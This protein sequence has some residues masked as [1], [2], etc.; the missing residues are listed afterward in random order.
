[1]DSQGMMRG[2]KQ[3]FRSPLLRG[4]GRRLTVLFRDT[5]HGNLRWLEEFDSLPLESLDRLKSPPYHPIPSN[6]SYDMIAQQNG[7]LMKFFEEIF[8]EI[9]FVPISV[10]SNLRLDSHVDS[11]HYCLPNSLLEQWVRSILEVIAIVDRY[12]PS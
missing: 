3:L 10:M 9:A 5:P 11:L 7:M 12:S 8:P 2:L 1:M 4:G 6:Y